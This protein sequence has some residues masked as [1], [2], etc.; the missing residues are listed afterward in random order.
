MSSF[1]ALGS[2]SMRLRIWKT[3]IVATVRISRGAFE[4]RRDQ[5]TF[6]FLPKVPAAFAFHELWPNR[7]RE[8]QNLAAAV[9]QAF[10]AGMLHLVSHLRKLCDSERLVIA[11]G[12]ALNSVANER[13]HR[14]SGFSDVYVIPAAEDSGV[15]IGAAYLGYWRLTDKPARCRLR[16]DSLGRRYT[17]DEVDAAI[18]NVPLI[19]E[20][21]TADPIKSAVELL[22]DGKIVA[23]FEGGAELGPRALGQRSILC[24][25]RR[26]DAKNYVNEM[27]KFREGFRPFAPAILK[28]EAAH[29]FQ[30]AGQ[31][32]DSRF[33]LRVLGFE[34]I[35]KTK[36][37]AVVHV[38]GTGRLQTVTP[39]DNGHLC[40]LVAEMFKRTGVPIL[41]NTS[42]NL[43]SEPI[44]ETPEDALWTMLFSGID[45]CL[46]E[47]RLVTKSEPTR[48]A[49]DFTVVAAAALEKRNNHT[50]LNISRPYLGEWSLAIPVGI[51]DYPI[52]AATVELARAR[53][54]GRELIHALR[55]RFG[56]RYGMLLQP[57]D[58]H[59]L[60]L[61]RRCGLIDLG[62]SNY[63]SVRER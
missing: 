12:C 6:K 46:I 9:Q 18:R 35:K 38:D 48:S 57:R 55:E 32:I 58:E 44:V 54:T 28:S 40:D 33:M 45:A 37:P 39:E 51:A 34:E 24:D 53:P 56:Q 59:A 63:R 4:N 62:L 11:G 8:Y 20:I 41:L 36:V 2:S 1:S 47:G 30:T 22:M 43:Q 19:E 21:S 16:R 42:F 15:S 23:L 17:H 61:M 50:V 13:I 25:P 49:L 26:P 14:E 31:S 29:W 60:A 3:P 27:V 52:I 5:G 7:K 10:E